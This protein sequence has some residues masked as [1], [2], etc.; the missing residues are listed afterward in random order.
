M[1]PAEELFNMETDRL[2]LINCARNPAQRVALE[3]MRKRYDSALGDLR[4]SAV[5]KHRVYS[6]LFDRKLPWKAKAQLLKGS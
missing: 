6:R 3:K 1:S 2:E 5:N 4:K